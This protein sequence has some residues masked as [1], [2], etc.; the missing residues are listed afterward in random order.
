MS[1]L[2]ITLCNEVVSKLPFER[3]CALAAALGYDGLEVAPFTLSD[4]PATLTAS[5]RAGYRAMAEA[6]G[7]TITGLHWLLNIPAGLS[8]TS[9][10]PDTH[11]RTR[12]HMAAMVDLCADLGGEVAVHGS[13]K[14]RAL[15]HAASPQRAREQALLLLR[16]AGERAHSAGVTY[17]IE[18]LPPGLTDY[19]TNVREALDIVEEINIPSLATM[20][21]TLSAWGGEVQPPADLIRRHLPSGR[22]RHIHLNDDN[23]RAPG[24]GK[25]R[26]APILQALAD[27]DYD[28]AVGIEPFDYHPDGP[29]AAARAIGYIRGIIETME[30]RA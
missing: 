12:D 1:R 20:I 23:M 8:I 21:D 13:P 3:Q 29:A 24:Q 26:F 9:D 5:Q 28:G 16:T 19:V 6:E 2:Q 11:R 15:A 25:R 22:I 7:I 30:G 17:C 10:D 18:P 27:L 14:Q 4:E